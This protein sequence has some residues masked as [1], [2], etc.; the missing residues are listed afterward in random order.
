MTYLIQPASH[1]RNSTP[2]DQ[3]QVSDWAEMIKIEPALQRLFNEAAAVKDD[4]RKRGFCANAHW[5]GYG[6]RTGLGLKPRMMQL[7]G[8]HASDPR[9]RSPQAYVEACDHVYSALPNCR[10]CNC[11]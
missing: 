7:V 10:N 11:M 6:S 3:D 8:W 5:Y 4:K 2:S 9:L 1:G